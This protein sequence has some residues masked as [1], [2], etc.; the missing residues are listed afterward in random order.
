MT[1]INQSSQKGFL[2]GRG[3]RY[4]GPI[5]PPMDK[6]KWGVIEVQLPYIFFGPHITSNE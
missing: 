5:P 2:G 4:S 1:C 3:I 6:N